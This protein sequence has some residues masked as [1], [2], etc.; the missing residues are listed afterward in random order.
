[1]KIDDPLE[2]AHLPTETS[3]VV[4][5][6]PGCRKTWL[7]VER[8]KWLMSQDLR[9]HATIAC[10]TYTNA[11][12]DEIGDRLPVGATPGFLGTI[13]SFLLKYILYPYSYLLDGFPASWDLVTKHFAKAHMDWMVANGH[14]S[15][16][17]AHIPDVLR[18]F[19]MIG[20]NINGTLR[21]IGHHG[22]KL[23]EMRHFVDRRLSVG[24]VSQQDVLW[25]SY[26]LLSEPKCS[27]IADALSCRFASI[28][29]DE[30]QDTTELQNAVFERLHTLKRTSLF[31][32]GDPD[33]SIFAFA[34]SSLQTFRAC[35]EKYATYELTETLRFTKH[36][37]A[38]LNTFLPAERALK[39][40]APWKHLDIP[41]YIMVGCISNAD[42]LREFLRLVQQH[43][44]VDK[45]GKQGKADYFVL[46]RGQDLFKELA[47]LD[48]GGSGETEDMLG[49]LEEKH[50]L[51][52]S[53]MEA[54]LQAMKY[55]TLDD[56]K[57][58]YLRLD[59]ALSRLILKANAGFGSP[60]VVGL[61][62]DSWRLMVISTLHRLDTSS[63]L[64]ARQWA[65][66]FKGIVAECINLAGGKKSGPKLKLLD[67]LEKVLKK[68]S[69]Y[70]I[71][72]ALQSVAL[73]EDAHESVRTIHTAKGLERDAVLLIASIPQQFSRWVKMD[74]G[75][76]VRDEESRIGYVAFSRAKK[77]LCVATDSLTDERKSWLEGLACVS[78]I[79]LSSPG[80]SN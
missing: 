80:A 13:H 8:V 58:A 32:V 25:F 47:R 4:Q 49:V 45:K 62:P 10:I 61:S 53:I 37:A 18:S 36:I 39:S 12:A 68:R 21:D 54:V 69:Q 20:Y 17:K 78:V 71:A 28:L 40:V 43:E 51:L 33:Q 79:N 24:Q 66:Q 7:L 48:G 42:R 15:V 60:A 46:A 11:A 3:C 6:G 14:L 57:R 75:K 22:L 70:P 5:A 35:T 64:D 38:F 19:E 23:E 44:L 77:L 65:A 72:C 59:Q 26:R 56:L 1:M 50:P 30:F 41:V 2:L 34:G 74:D 63:A 9:P 31:L 52:H 67:S 76:S 16:R 73:P 27:H 55:R 29:V